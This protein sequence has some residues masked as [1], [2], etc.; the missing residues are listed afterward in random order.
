MMAQGSIPLFL[1]AKAPVAGQV[2]K[3]LCPPLN[4][5]QACEVANALLRHAIDMLESHWP[6]QCV[7]CVTPDVG[8]VAFK[9]VVQS[10]RWKTAI[11]AETDLGGRMCLAL[12]Q[13]IN[14][15]GSAAVLGADIPSI[16]RDILQYAH[17]CLARGQQCV[18]PSVDGGFYFLGVNKSPHNLFRD[19]TWGTSDVYAKLMENA[20]AKGVSLKLLPMLSDCD[21]YEDLQTAARTLPAFAKCLQQAGFDMENL[22]HR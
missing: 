19:I 15:A 14:A 21:Y 18:G 13:G 3:R 11:Q 7:L 9:P 20:K 4:P 17:Q 12:E 16:S 6:G 10:N 22:S 1:F 5:M 2:K 8:H